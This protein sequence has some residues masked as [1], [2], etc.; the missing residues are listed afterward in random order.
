M[1]VRKADPQTAKELSETDR[2]KLLAIVTLDSIE[3]P[4]LIRMALTFI[5]DLAH[6]PRRS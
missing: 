4:K 3:E 6:R 1:L 2:Q 5:T